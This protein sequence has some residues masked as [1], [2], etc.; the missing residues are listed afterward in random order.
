MS[1][2]SLTKRQMII[3]RLRR[4]GCDCGMMASCEDAESGR[5]LFV[6]A[7]VGQLWGIG[8]DKLM[9]YKCRRYLAVSCYARRIVAHRRA[10]KEA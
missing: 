6:M 3:G 9:W 5:G 1:M 7:N 4:T 8:Y 10:E 2:A